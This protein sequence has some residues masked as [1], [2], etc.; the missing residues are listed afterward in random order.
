MVDDGIPVNHCV[1]PVIEE[2]PCRLFFRP[3]TATFRVNRCEDRA[4]DL[5][6]A[7]IAF[8]DIPGVLPDVEPEM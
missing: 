7:A 8:D 1:Q 3:Y 6:S 5:S 2:L 4:W